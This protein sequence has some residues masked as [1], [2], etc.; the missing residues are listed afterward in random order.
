MGVLRQ[1]WIPEGRSGVDGAYVSFPCEDLLG[2]LA[3]ESRTHG[4]VVVGED[5]GTVPKGFAARLARHAIL[6]SRVMFFERTRNGG[7]RRAAAYSPRALVTA[8]THDQ[9]TLAGWWRGRD[10]EIRRAVGMI[11][12]DDALEAAPRERAQE[13]QLLLERLR[14]ERALVRGAPEEPAALCE[15][16]IRYLSSTPSVLQGVSLDDL[17]GETEP[18]NVPGVGVEQYPSWSR[19]MRLDVEDLARDP[20]VAQALRGTHARARTHKRRRR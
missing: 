15:A 19:R 10:I 17:A 13:K 16:V 2:L 3:L 7:F 12:D 6:S 11:G 5:L 1:F 18:V 20:G 14:A 9:P 4:A 8:N